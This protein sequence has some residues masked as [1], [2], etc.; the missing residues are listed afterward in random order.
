VTSLPRWLWL[1]VVLA[2]LAGAIALAASSYLAYALVL[3]VISGAAA[4]RLIPER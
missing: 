3:P 4:T 2:C 1:A